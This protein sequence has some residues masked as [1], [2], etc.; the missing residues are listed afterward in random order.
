MQL[1]ER[2]DAR[3]VFLGK[4]CLLQQGLNVGRRARVI[5]R[6]DLVAAAV[7]ADVVTERDVA[8]ERKLGG[9]GSLFAAGERGLVVL[10][11]D[12][13]MESVGRRIRRIAR[14]GN[15]EFLQKSF[16]GQLYAGTCGVE[17][18]IEKPR[19]FL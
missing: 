19:K 7:E 14:C 3:E 16:I 18:H 2:L 11:R 9:L 8:V 12:A 13:A 15:V 6:D 1:L 17:I 4:I 10:R 5:A